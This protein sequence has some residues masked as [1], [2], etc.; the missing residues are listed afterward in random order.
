MRPCAPVISRSNVPLARKSP[1]DPLRNLIMIT[2][3]LCAIGYFGAGG[4]SMRQQQHFPQA[5]FTA[6][7][8]AGRGLHPGDARQRGCDTSSSAGEHA[9]LPAPLPWIIYAARGPPSGRSRP[10]PAWPEW[11]C[12]L[13]RAP[14]G[15]LR[16][17]SIAAA[18]QR[19]AWSDG[20]P[21]RQEQFAMKTPVPMGS[22]ARD[23]FLG[24]APWVYRVRTAAAPRRPAVALAYLF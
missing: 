13:A 17:L 9:P 15:I 19:P 11:P 20:D 18:A 22:V 16:Q 2:Y 3:D 8:S 12:R 24:R 21:T 10:P 4:G 14:G 23:V 7:T 1:H 5:N 6:P